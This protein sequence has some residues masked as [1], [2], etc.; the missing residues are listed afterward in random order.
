MKKNSGEKILEKINKK[1]FRNSVLNFS[2]AMIAR[3][4]GLILTILLARFLLPELFGI[5]HLVLSIV[6]V[7]FTFTD[8]GIKSALS[9]YVSFSLKTNNRTRARS[10]LKYLLKIKGILLLVAIILMFILAPFLSREIYNQPLIL[11]PLVFATVYIF[12]NALRS[13][14][15]SIFFPIKDLSKYPF[16]TLTLH[17]L[18][19]IFSLLVLLLVSREFAVTGIFIGFALA[20]LISLGVVFLALGKNKDL[21]FGKTTRIKK[22]V[23]NKYVGFMSIAS[24]SFVIFAATDTL[25][26]GYFVNPAYIGFYSAAFGL[27]ASIAAVYSLSNIFLPVFTQ[28]EKKELKFEF[29]KA[30][31]YISLISVP[32]VIGLILVGKQVINL[33]YGSEYVPAILPLYALSLLVIVIPSLAIYSSL[34]ESKEKTKSIAFFAFVSLVINIVL[35]FLLISYFLNFGENMAILGAGIATFTSQ[36]IHLGFLLKRAKP[37]FN[38]KFPFHKFGKPLL[39]SIFMLA[40]LLVYEA[41]IPK[42]LFTLIP[43]IILGAVV[44]FSFLFR[45]KGINKEDLKTFKN[46]FKKS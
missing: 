22:P 45:I 29:E 10:Y 11:V 46:I 3:F 6:L 7:V 17:S 35:N 20:S 4:S 24:V 37:E 18:R 33:I 30:F 39:A 21:I 26:L 8:L 44:Y 13:F 32:S 38:L 12:I 27:I 23:V 25:V 34:F 40:V 14:F 19:L 43:E 42:N 15:E 1:I 31:K 2:S 36:T 28:I 5:Y 16:T 41:I 9:R